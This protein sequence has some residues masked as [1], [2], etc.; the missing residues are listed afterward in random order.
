SFSHTHTH[1]HTHTCYFCCST[2]ESALQEGCLLLV[3]SAFPV[4]LEASHTNTHTPPHTLTCL[5][6]FL[7]SLF[8]S[9]SVS[10]PWTLFLPLELSFSPSLSLPLILCFLPLC[11]SLSLALSLS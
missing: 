7:P 11:S 8:L 10:L 2:E 9:L 3:V 4:S 6:V 5:P 1:T